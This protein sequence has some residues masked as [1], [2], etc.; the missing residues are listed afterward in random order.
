M[1]HG[2]KKLLILRRHQQQRVTGI[3]VNE[4]MQLPR[5]VRRTLRAVDHRLK[6]GKEATMTPEQ[7]AGM[8]AFEAMIIGR[9]EGKE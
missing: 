1:V 5:R 2:R 6:T 9:R 4:K 7:L 8:R 3:V